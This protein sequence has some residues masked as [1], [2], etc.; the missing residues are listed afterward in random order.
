[1]NGC[2]TLTSSLTVQLYTKVWPGSAALVL[3]V[4]APDG[5][6]LAGKGSLF[7]KTTSKTSPGSWK[8]LGPAA[9]A[10]VS[11]TA[12]KQHNLTL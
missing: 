8:S 7:R 3:L 11:R 1:M 12:V 9:G 2:A 4:K 5:T 10:V 6:M